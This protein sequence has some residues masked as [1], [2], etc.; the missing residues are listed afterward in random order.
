MGLSALR[1]PMQTAPALHRSNFSFCKPVKIHKL[2]Y[3]RIMKYRSLKVVLW[4]SIVTFAL[5]ACPTLRAAE[6]N[7][8]AAASLTDALKEIGASYEKQSGDKIAFNF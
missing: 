4:F 2:N 3:Q 5:S 1:P 8:F 6:I 7:V